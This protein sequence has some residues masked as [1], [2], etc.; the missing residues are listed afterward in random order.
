MQTIW[1]ELLG[2]LPK[3][4][5][6]YSKGKINAEPLVEIDGEQ[7]AENNAERKKKPKRFAK[8]IAP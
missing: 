2:F 4:T 1:Q 5:I 8:R 6:F 7:N 3:N